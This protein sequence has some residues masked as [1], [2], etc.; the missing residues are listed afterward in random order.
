MSMR[1]HETA[2]SG[3][4]E[5]SGSSLVRDLLAILGRQAAGEI[6]QRASGISIYGIAFRAGHIGN[7]R[8]TSVVARFAGNQD[9]FGHVCSAAP[10]RGRA[11]FAR[12]AELMT[13]AAC[14]DAPIDCESARRVAF[15]APTGGENIMK[16]EY[17]MN[18]PAVL[19]AS[20]LGTKLGLFCALIL[21][22][23]LI[24][25]L[26]VCITPAPDVSQFASSVVF[27]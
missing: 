12:A 11:L 27:P 15:N 7:L 2:R 25:I 5:P 22:P 26:A 19:R 24:A 4:A 18:S 13:G 10:G 1:H 14:D 17:D 16:L 9:R 6:L 23:L 3:R 8:T 20:V 21:V